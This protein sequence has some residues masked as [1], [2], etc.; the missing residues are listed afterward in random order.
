MLVVHGGMATSLA[1]SV[2]ATTLLQKLSVSLVHSC[3]IFLPKFLSHSLYLLSLLHS[4]H[5]L[6]F[7][8]VCELLTRLMASSTIIFPLL[9]TRPAHAESPWGYLVEPSSH[10]MCFSELF[11]YSEKKIDQGFKFPSFGIFLFRH[12]SYRHQA[13]EWFQWCFMM[14]KDLSYAL[15][16]SLLTTPLWKDGGWNCWLI[17]RTFS[18][19][20]GHATRL[21]F[22]VSSELGCGHGLCRNLLQEFC[23]TLSCPQQTYGDRGDTGWSMD[24]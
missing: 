24:L 10:A 11:R 7:P 2:E 17:T 4:S 14:D 12:L 23:H 15:T 20:P 13:I 22:P 6:L 16:H 8:E 21:H 1:F 19:V 9:P 5:W 18:I 3:Y